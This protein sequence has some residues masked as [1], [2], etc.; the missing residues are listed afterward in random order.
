MRNL[1]AFTALITPT[2][3]LAATPDTETVA[4]NIV[5]DLT[6]EV[7][8]RMAGSPREAAARDWAVAR[9][10]ALGFANVRVEPFTI[11]GF[12]R[13]AETA[14]LTTPY[15]QNLHIT[16][17]GYSVPTPKGG[18]TAELVYFPSLAALQTAPSGSLTGKIAF[19]DNQMRRNQEGSGYGPYGNARRR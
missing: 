2:L 14:R 16:A 17:L 10:K 1:L 15:P 13:G 12:V 4:W 7:G 11:R 9:L 18:L 19:I 3:A 6:T 5:A 8:Q